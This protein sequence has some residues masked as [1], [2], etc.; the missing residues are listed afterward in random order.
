MSLRARL[1]LMNISLIGGIFLLFGAL[2][3]SLVSVVLI[4]QIDETLAQTVEDIGGVT[5]I[6]QVGELDVITLPSLDLASNVYVQAWGRDGRLRSNS[7]NIN[8]L[9]RPLDP[10]GM[11]AVDPIYRDSV[12][13]SARLRVLTVPLEIN[14]RPVGRLQ[15]GVSLAVVQDAQQALLLVM[16]SVAIVLIS[17]SGAASWLMTQSALA[18]LVLATRRALEITTA[19][20]LSR[21]I[22][23][24]DPE[25]DEIGMLIR[26][27]NQTLSRMERLINAQRRFLTD[28]GH[29]FRTPLTVIRGN[30][31]LMKKMGSLDD[32]SL[33][34]IQGEVGRLTRLVGD[35]LLLAQAESGKLPLARQ[36]IAL[37]TVL[38]EVYRQVQV[39]SNEAA[40]V[41]I[42]EIDQ[43]QVCGDEDRLKQVF[44][45]LIGNAVKYTPKDGLVVISLGKV[46]GQSRFT[47]S[48][49]GPGIPPED[50]PHIFDRFYRGEKSRL[51]TK[52]GKGFG[53]GLSIAY[54]IVRNHGGRIEV[55]STV[56][57][58]T[59][60]SIWLPLAGDSDCVEE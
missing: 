38:L 26:A 47:I 11:Q 46:G 19:N 56:D 24:P 27:F 21:R 31:D 44:L 58:G 16:V 36:L 34:S 29:E 32:E 45:N 51:R 8:N 42:G 43:V 7:Q 55:D 23:V 35:L 28:V 2:V 17:I 54:W 50:L 40:T 4:N 3:Y 25:D 49:T 57:Q 37:D 10:L 18:P 53:L 12:V 6:N 33:T 15:V 5:T 52:D 13:G 22:P 48:D 1:T 20:D 39:L 14:D 30:V 59:T 41:R 9:R 60:F